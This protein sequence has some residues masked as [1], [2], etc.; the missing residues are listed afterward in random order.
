MEPKTSCTDIKPLSFAFMMLL[1]F[2]GLGYSP[3]IT[4]EPKS[5]TFGVVPQQS[6]TKLARNWVPILKLLSEKTG[7]DLR[8]ATAPDI[9]TFEKRLSDGEYDFAYMNPYHYTVFHEN[10]GYVA[11]AKR[12]NKKITGI[13]VVRED[14]DYQSVNDLDGQVLVFPAPAAFAATLLVRSSLNKLKVAHEPKFVSSHDSVYRAVA[15][16]FADAGGGIVR[17][18]NTI[19]P[20]IR[21]QLRVLW[22]SEGY[23]P[24][25]FAVH[26]R[27]PSDM[28]GKLR[29]AMLELHT[30]EKGKAALEKLN[31]NEIEA[32]ENHDWDDVR[33]LKIQPSMV[34]IEP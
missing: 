26:S 6:A 11:F 19:D 13:I 3:Q 25:A 22:K 1:L 27:I 30:E 32:A 24:H 23:T 31:I 33:A 14:S 21:S 9:P 2:S 8:F 12:A 10:P 5:Y 20:S 28:V 29:D 16:K 7:V 15:G 18:L 17:T 4:A 34:D